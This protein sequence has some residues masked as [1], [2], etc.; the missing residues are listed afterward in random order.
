MFPGLWMQ[1]LQLDLCGRILT[2]NVF[3]S[4]IAKNF[5]LPA[6]TTVS[7]I[8]AYQLTDFGLG[9][10]ARSAS[11]L[12]SVNLSQ[13]S[14]LTNKGINLLVKHLKSTLIDLYIDHCQNIDAVSMLPAMRK[15]KC[16]EVLSV[17]GIETVDDH[18]VTEIVREHG[19]NMRELVL[20]NCG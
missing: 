4:T 9:T 7:L 8:G 12:R 17:A 13:C 1:V 20:A 16:L 11:A 6:F 19:S 14:L 10:L 5:N 2:E 15:L 3:I 18:F